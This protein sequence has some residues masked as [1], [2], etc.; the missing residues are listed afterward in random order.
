MLKRII[1]KA[2][3]AVGYDV[4][5]TVPPDMDEVFLKLYRECKNYTV[6]SI[7]RMFSLYEATRYITENIIPG[8]IVECGVWRGGSSMICASMLRLM[9]D[10]RRKIFMYDTYAGMTD[11][12]DKDIDYTGNKASRNDFNKWCAI[13]RSIV[14][15]AMVLTGYPQENIW[16]V[17]GKVED[18]IPGVIPETIALLRLDTDFYESTYHEL[19]WL[20]PRLVSGGV[21]I[22]DDYGHFRGVREAV[23]KYIKENSV[24]ILLNRIDYTGRIGVKC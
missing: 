3:N 1:R 5:L 20:F 10:T 14:E 21:L 17:E 8:D 16:Y 19:K 13:P 11:P 23:D 12:T 2:V 22:V 4:A 18:T 7:E 6:T 9:G 15:Q 24:R